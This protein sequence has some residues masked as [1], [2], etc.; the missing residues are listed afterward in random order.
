M[1]W[2]DRG[3]AAGRDPIPPERCWLAQGIDISLGDAA[4]IDSE[5]LAAMCGPDGLGGGG[6]RSPAFAQDAHA[7]ALSPSPVLAALTEAAVAEVTRL[8]DN[9]LIGVLQAA[10]RQENREAWKKALVIAEFARRR[11]AEFDAARRGAFPST[12]DLASSL[13]RSSRSSSLPARSRPPTRS[14]TPPT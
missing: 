12:A 9:Q 7:D 1:A 4:D 11:A 14:T 13:A 5:L 6:A 3:V 8:S 10:R 2:V